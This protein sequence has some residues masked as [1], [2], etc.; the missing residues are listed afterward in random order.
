[1]VCINYEPLVSVVIAAYNQGPFL[2][3]AIDSA[4]AQ[5]YPRVEIIIV[6]DGSTDPSTRETVARYAGRVHYVEQQHAGVAVAR[7]TGVAAAAGELIAWLDHDDVWLPQ[8]LRVGVNALRAHPDVALF[9]ANYYHIDA[10]G[11]RVSVT[12]LPAGEW[13]PLPSLLL[14]T[15][16]SPC[17]TLLRRSLFTE[18]GPLDPGLSHAEDWYWTLLLALRG[19]RFYCI[20]EPLAEYRWHEENT[21]RK[22]DLMLPAWIAMLDKFF[23]LPGLPPA[24]RAYRRRAYFSR[25]ADATSMYY[26]AG[27]IAE[28]RAQLHNATQF[29]PAGVTTGRFLTSLV[30]SASHQPTRATVLAAI[31]FVQTELIAVGAPP[32][33]VQKFQARGRLALALHSGSFRPSA[34]QEMVRALRADPRLLVDR[35]IWSAG[36]RLL[37]RNLKR[38]RNATPGYPRTL[39]Q[40]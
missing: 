3:R 4:L 6:N 5:T 7:N 27:R 33:L 28:A 12:H 1:M 14:D 30:Y 20:A 36:G 18:L 17:T 39:D 19:G 34:L 26:G 15:P 10:T 16:I 25:Y 40:Q 38:V 8:R 9:H 31:R 2:A 21:F 22:P 23:A 35:E 37:A 29:F 32:P 13:Q 11:Q 24:V